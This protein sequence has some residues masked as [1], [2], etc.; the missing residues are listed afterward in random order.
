MIEIPLTIT[1]VKTRSLQFPCRVRSFHISGKKAVLA[2]VYDIGSLLQTPTLLQTLVQAGRIDKY[3]EVS[4]GPCELRAA[5]ASTYDGA[6]EPQGLKYPQ[7]FR[8]RGRKS[9]RHL[10][11][12]NLP[13]WHLFT[14]YTVCVRQLGRRWV[15]CAYS[16]AKYSARPGTTTRR[17]RATLAPPTR[18]RDA[19][20][21]R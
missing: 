14:V 16:T 17:S 11:T 4:R 8:L 13:W 15:R 3:R 21:V 5:Y 2:G 1:S 10:T 20:V 7:S 9:S 18:A 6:L 19:R 12:L